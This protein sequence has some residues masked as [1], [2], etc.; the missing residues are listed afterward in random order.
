[1]QTA[2][3]K[4]ID[5]LLNKDWNL[6]GGGYTVKKEL[7]TVDTPGKFN[8]F[9]DIGIRDNDL[10][11]VLIAIEIEHLSNSA[12]AMQNIEKLKTWAHNSPKRKCGLLHIFNEGCNPY[13]NDICRLVDYANKN[14]KKDKGFYYEYTFYS[15]RRRKAETVA[16]EIIQSKNFRARLYQLLTY[17]DSCEPV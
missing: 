5:K 12:Q 9:V 17:V 6:G 7:S 1:L 15:R 13:E 2:L 14:Q 4:E 3:A 16:N 11:T 8:G 10:P